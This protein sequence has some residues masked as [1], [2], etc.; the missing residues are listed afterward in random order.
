MK[1]YFTLLILVLGLSSC[2]DGVQFNNP[3]FQGIKDGQL[4][5]KATGYTV[6]IDETTGFLTFVGNDSAGTLTLRVPSASIGTYVLANVP[7]M[8]ASFLDD[9]SLAFS[10]NNVGGRGPFN[11]SDGE[12][13]IEEIDFTNNTFT[14]TFRFN[15]YSADGLEVVNFMEGVFYKLPLSTGV[16]P[17][18]VVTCIDVQAETSQAFQTFLAADPTN[19]IEYSAACEAYKTALQRQRIYCGDSNGALQN[20][21]DSLG[22]CAP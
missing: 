17:A 2:G 16:I 11:F 15:A 18:N 21:I 3:S 1:K 4:L 12:I 19:P 5:W 10:T 14:G 6:T 7:S 13:V 22:D 20:R 9:N 8:E